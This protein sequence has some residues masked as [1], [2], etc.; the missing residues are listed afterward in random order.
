MVDGRRGEGWW[1]VGERRVRWWG[2]DRRRVE[3]VGCRWEGGEVV[4]GV[5]G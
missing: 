3:V 5:G 1:G 2:I 4:V